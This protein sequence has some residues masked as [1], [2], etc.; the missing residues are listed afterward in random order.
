M[1]EPPALPRCRSSRQFELLQSELPN[2]VGLRRNAPNLV[3][4]MGIATGEAV[5]GT[6][7]SPISKSFTLIRDTVE[8]APR[9]QSIN[10]GYR[11]P[12][13]I[14]RDTL[15]PG[16]HEIRTPERDPITVARQNQPGRHHR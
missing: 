8:L 10:K 1:R 11:T 3:V 12:L 2:I 13:I 16:Q 5:V 14:A 7:G 4:R 9:L 6:I 15:R